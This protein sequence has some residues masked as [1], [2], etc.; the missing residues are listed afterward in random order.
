MERKPYIEM[1]VWGLKRKACLEL[2]VSEVKADN[3]Y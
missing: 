2:L 1:L 3:V